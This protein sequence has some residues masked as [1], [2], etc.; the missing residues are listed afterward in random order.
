MNMAFDLETAGTGGAEEAGG[1]A[2][3]HPRWPDLVAR[4]VAAREASGALA[5]ALR[6]ASHAGSGSFSNVA[7]A[8]LVAQAARRA[9]V[10]PNDLGNRKSGEATSSPTAGETSTGGRGK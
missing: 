8:I 2:G 1:V 7:A 3:R 4:M 9:S 10:N 6:S 5:P